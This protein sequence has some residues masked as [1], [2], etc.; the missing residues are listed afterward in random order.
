[1]KHVA[2]PLAAWR[3]MVEDMQDLVTDPDGQRAKLRELA[4]LAYQRYQV[5]ANEL[6]DMLEVTDAA[7]E[8]GLLELEHGYY[9]GLF[10]RPEHDLEPGTQCF[11]KGRLIRVL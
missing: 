2:D 10:Q 8:W 5:D 9:L 1:M 11:Y 7:R 4:M 6:S 3:L